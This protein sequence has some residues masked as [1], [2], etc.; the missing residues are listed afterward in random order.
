MITINKFLVALVS[1]LGVLL[2]V[3][4]GGITD[5]EW[6][7]LAIEAFGAAGVYGVPYASNPPSVTR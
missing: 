7:I 4:D 2:V 5:K 3:I 1:A 6:I